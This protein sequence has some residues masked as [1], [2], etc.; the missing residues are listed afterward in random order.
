[1]GPLTLSGVFFVIALVQAFHDPLLSHCSNPYG[2]LFIIAHHMLALY[3][4]TGSLFFGNHKTH[5]VVVIGAFVVHKMY[6][7]CPLTT[8]HNEICGLDLKTPLYTIFNHVTHT[9]SQA[10]CLYYFVIIVVVLYDLEH[11]I[12]TRAAKRPETSLY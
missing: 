2:M 10:I 1:M 7:I 3:L 8:W 5:L 4:I 12:P 11:V 6:K 9:T